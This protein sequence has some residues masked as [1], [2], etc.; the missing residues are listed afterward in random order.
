MGA[1]PAS[2]TTW[3]VVPRTVTATE[4]A[5]V[6]VANAQLTDGVIRYVHS[7][8]GDAAGDGLQPGTAY[9]TIDQAINASSAGDTIIVLEAHAESIASATTLV[10]DKAG[11]TIIGL[12][13]GARR[14]TLTFTAT[15]SNIPISAAG[16][17]FQNFLMT[18]SGTTDVTA[19]ITITAAD[20]ELIDIE[21]RDAGTT[22]QFTDFIVISNVAADRVRIENVKIVGLAGDAGAAGISITTA[23]SEIEIVDPWIVGTFSAGCIENI[24]NAAID[25]MISNARLEQRHAT[26]DAAIDLVATTSGFINGAAIRTATFDVGG[27]DLALTDCDDIQMFGVEVVNVDGGVGVPTGDGASITKIYV[28]SNNG[29]TG[30]SGLQRSR[31]KATIDQAI[32]IA[33]VGDTIVV[34]AGHAESIAN[35]TSLVPDVNGISIIGEG[36]GSRRPT[37][38]FTN[39]AANIPIS[40]TDIL[41]KNFLLTISG[42]TDVAIGITVTGDGCV[43]EDVEMTEPTTTDQFIVGIHATTM[44]GGVIRGLDFLGLAGDAGITGIRMTDSERLEITDCRIVG[45]FQGSEDATGAIQSLTTLNVDVSIH[46]NRVENRDGTS[47]AGI[48]FVATDTGFVY[49]NFIAVPTADFPNGM[50]VATA[51]RQYN[52]WVVDVATERGAPTGTASA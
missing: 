9:A 5:A 40:G 17:S 47:E 39:N 28:D 49:E 11:I 43:V 48:V 29:A 18:V 35:A 14:P 42:T 36:I 52:N 27:F 24:T 26:Q 8:T 44:K 46:H 34:M 12:G 6:A 2:F 41:F 37:I 32:N 25:L 15:G 38:T 51:M 19:G 20:V 33:R 3:G 1:I 22:D 23:T 13:R 16:V 30:F 21:M 31:A 7:V 10:P 50:V 4:K 45:N